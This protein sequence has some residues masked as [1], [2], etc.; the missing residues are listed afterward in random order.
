M[1]LELNRC[2]V[3]P[4]EKYAAIDLSDINKGNLDKYNIS[5]ADMLKNIPYINC[6]SR[7]ID[8]LYMGLSIEMQ[9]SANFS[10]CRLMDIENIFHGIGYFRENVLYPKRLMK[11]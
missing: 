4:F 10:I 3:E 8:K 1:P 7:E 11:R 5:I 6:N 9:N 2:I